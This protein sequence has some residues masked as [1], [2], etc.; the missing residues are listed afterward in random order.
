M[1]VS[2]PPLIETRSLC[3]SYRNDGIETPVLFDIDLRIERGEFVAIMGPSGS[4]KST[5]M[6]ILGFLDGHTSGS[7]LFQGSPTTSFDDD[8]LAR[9][10]ATR[11]S[12]VFQ[13][14]NLLPGRP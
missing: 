12:F 14:F 10:R 6:H 7:Y 9:I 2:A 3:K 8:D 4:G 5:L 1:P 13:A 11:V